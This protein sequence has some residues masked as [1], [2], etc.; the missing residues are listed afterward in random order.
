MFFNKEDNKYSGVLP[1]DTPFTE[2]DKHLPVTVETCLLPY[3]GKIVWHGI[4]GIVKEY[5]LIRKL[6]AYKYMRASDRFV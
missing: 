2:L 3:N 5:N 4:A 1:I 6:F